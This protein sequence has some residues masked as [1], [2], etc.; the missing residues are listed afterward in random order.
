[1][2][3]LSDDALATLLR[4]AEPLHP[5]L[6]SPFLRDVAE[7]LRGHAEIGDGLVAR[8]GREVQ[9]RYLRPP[10]IRAEPFEGGRN[11]SRSY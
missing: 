10:S 8:I 9:A 7:A 3:A 6:R 1:M 11:R 4:L 2:I 5:T